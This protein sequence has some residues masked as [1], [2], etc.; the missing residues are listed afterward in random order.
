MSLETPIAFFIFNRPDLT[1]LVFD[2]TRQ[3]K[4][5][6]LLV[7]ADGPRLNVPGDF[8]KCK[9][10]RNIIEK[11]DW[12]CEVLK[13]YSD[14]NLGCGE[15]VSSGLNW[16]FD[17]VSEAIILEDDCLPDLTFFRFCEEMLCKYK[18]DE[19]IMMISGTNLM[20]DWKSDLQSYHFSLYGGI[21][22]W[23]T[24]KRA[25]KYYDYNMDLL[26]RKDIKKLI[27][28]LLDDEDQYHYNSTA[29]SKTQK[30]EIDTWDFQWNFARFIKS[31]LSIVP[32]VNLISNL[33]IRNDSTHNID[34]IKEIGNLPL[35][36]ILFPLKEPS[37]ISIDRKYDRE[38][39]IK[40]TNGGIIKKNN[41][42]LRVV[43]S[44][45]KK[46]VRIAFL[47]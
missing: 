9:E 46:L 3:A 2:A 23:A 11:V 16:V 32:S 4:P 19:R 44:K 31:G 7:V 33:G 8:D 38:F 12:D 43:K 17:I 5:K 10:V 30:G 1:K 29:F 36:Q 37:E 22:G 35:R 6:K 13:N 28:S 40:I 27:R 42:I 45:I 25:W 15:R 47:N 26:E 14:N 41:N 18:E 20:V 34:R 24:W 21:W 39:F